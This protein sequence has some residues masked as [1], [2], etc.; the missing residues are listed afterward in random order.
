MK[1][2]SI[3]ATAKDQSD[4]YA[5]VARYLEPDTRQWTTV[6][7]GLGTKS[8]ISALRFVLSARYQDGLDQATSQDWRKK[9]LEVVM[10]IHIINGNAGPPSIEA[11][12]VW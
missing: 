7:A 12:H 11:V 8:N 3:D 9:N 1:N 6:I 2:W 5:L 10:K 4:E